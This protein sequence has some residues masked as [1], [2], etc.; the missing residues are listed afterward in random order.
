[1]IPN[2]TAGGLSTA[3][4][5]RFTVTLGH[6][7]NRTVTSSGTRCRLDGEVELAVV[8]HIKMEEKAKARYSLNYQHAVHNETVS[9]ILVEFC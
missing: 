3:T 6:G 1:M 2:E 9:R 7:V 8:R 4:A 5:K